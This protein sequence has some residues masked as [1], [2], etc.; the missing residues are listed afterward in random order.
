ME[1]AKLVAS[2]GPQESEMKG[3]IGSNGDN[4]GEIFTFC[5]PHGSLNRAKYLLNYRGRVV[6]WRNDVKDDN[7]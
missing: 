1:Q 3:I 5:I 7:G 2:Q 4:E 6:L